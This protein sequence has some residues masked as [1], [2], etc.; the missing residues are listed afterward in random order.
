MKKTNDIKEEVYKCSKCGLCKSVCPLYLAT[1]NELY[2]PR[3]RNILLNDFFSMGKKLSKK[4]INELDICLNCNA[5]KE[6]CPSAIDSASI[7]ISLK[8]H[9]RVFHNV[10]I[11]YIKYYI[12]NALNLQE[13]L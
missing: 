13:V 12:I 5:C 6:F 10:C 11:F 2:S 4:F 9:T 8:M 3:G 1:K 7:Y